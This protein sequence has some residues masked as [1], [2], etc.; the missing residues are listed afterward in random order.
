M[1]SLNNLNNKLN[2]VTKKI[3]SGIVSAAKKATVAVA[4]IGTAAGV[5]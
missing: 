4:A 1:T 5:L 2:N 3:G